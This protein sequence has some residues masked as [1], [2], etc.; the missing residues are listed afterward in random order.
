M[1]SS[2][3]HVYKTT[4]AVVVHTQNISSVLVTT[5]QEAGLRTVWQLYR[6]LNPCDLCDKMAC[7]L[8]EMVWLDQKIT[9]KQHTSI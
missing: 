4:R 3:K 9:T 8:L 2:K 5:L 6:Q 7:L 1:W